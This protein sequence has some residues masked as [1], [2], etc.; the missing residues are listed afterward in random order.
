MFSGMNI[1]DSTRQPRPKVCMTIIEDRFIILL[2]A[3]EQLSFSI[4]LTA[5]W[6]RSRPW[7]ARSMVPRPFHISACNYIGSTIIE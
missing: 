6:R 2:Y 3:H 4:I 5:N 1:L 7:P